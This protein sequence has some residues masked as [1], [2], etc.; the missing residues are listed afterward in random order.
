MPV[1]GYLAPIRAGFL[2]VAFETTRPKRP[3]LTFLYTGERNQRHHDTTN[4]EPPPWH[5]GIIPSHYM[6]ICRP[7]FALWRQLL[8]SWGLWRPVGF[9]LQPGEA[10]TKGNMNQVDS[11]G[12][13]QARNIGRE[14]RQARVK[15]MKWRPWFNLHQPCLLSLSKIP[16][17]VHH[18]PFQ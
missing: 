5:C 14:N 17:E 9:A 10:G 7:R 2:P 12:G 4:Q 1:P 6:N 13:R 15:K 11:C 3:P 18:R 16:C 8:I